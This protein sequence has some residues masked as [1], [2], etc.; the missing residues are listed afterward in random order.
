MRRTRVGRVV[1]EL[2]L[3]HP[4]EAKRVPAQRRVRHELRLELA[5]RERHLPTAEAGA[6]IGCISRN[7]RVARWLFSAGVRDASVNVI[8]IIVTIVI[9]VTIITYC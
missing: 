7:R 1:V 2:A 3:L 8:N 5:V 6:A 4:L 9:T